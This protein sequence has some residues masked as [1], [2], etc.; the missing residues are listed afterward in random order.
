MLSGDKLGGP[1][2]PTQKDKTEREGAEYHIERLF[3][4][5]DLELEGGKTAQGKKRRSGTGVF[6]WVQK[7]HNLSTRLDCR[8]RSRPTRVHS[9]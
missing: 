7:F 5:R 4:C 6:P 9:G 2:P 3:C 1:P 8:L